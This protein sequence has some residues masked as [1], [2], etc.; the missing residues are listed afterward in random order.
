MTQVAIADSGVANLASITSGLH[1]I[2]LDPIITTDPAAF[3]AA[4]YAVLPGV[5]SFGAGSVLSGS[6]SPS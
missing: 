4:P 6:P 2:G 3:V 5:G 1:A